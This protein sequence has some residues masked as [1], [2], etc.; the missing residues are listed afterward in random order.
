MKTGINVN[1]GS[2]SLSCCTTA[3]CW[4]IMMLASAV[5]TEA[6][7]VIDGRPQRRMIWPVKAIRSA[8]WSADIFRQTAH[9][10]NW[11][12]ETSMYGREWCDDRLTVRCNDDWLR[13]WRHGSKVACRLSRC[14]TE[15]AKRGS[16]KQRRTM[17]HGLLFK[18]LGEIRTN[19]P[20]TGARGAKCRLDRVGLKCDFR[21]ITRYILRTVRRIVTARVAR[22]YT[23]FLV[24]VCV[25]VCVCMRVSG[26]Q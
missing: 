16:R 4:S 22:M 7:S 13:I 11:Q 21:Q 5:R 2:D 25:C 3:M 14:S 18:G 17:A 1:D 8:G 12:R 26:C 9:I 23:F 24:C 15:A 6:P 10:G 19:S 20:L